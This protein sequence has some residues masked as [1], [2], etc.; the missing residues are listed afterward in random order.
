MVVGIITF[1]SGEPEKKDD[2]KRW[3]EEAARFVPL[4]VANEVW[5]SSPRWVRPYYPAASS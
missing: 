4:D 1:R 3:L 5:G 2:I